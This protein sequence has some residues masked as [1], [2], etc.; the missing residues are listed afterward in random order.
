MDT[1]DNRIEHPPRR[2]GRG[3]PT[4]EEVAR[5]ERMTAQPVVLTSRVPPQLC[6]HCGR[7]M[8]PRILRRGSVGGR[9][10]ADCA[11][12]SCGKAFRYFFA[13]VETR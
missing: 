6:P 7:G 5:R 2:R 8:Q 10:Y 13:E 9:P 12:I 3:R 11:C 1:P 4:K